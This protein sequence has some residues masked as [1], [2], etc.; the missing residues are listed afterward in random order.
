[1]KLEKACESRWA[2]MTRRTRASDATPCVEDCG[3]GT[4]CFCSDA[5]AAWPR[6]TRLCGLSLDDEASAWRPES[7][8]ALRSLLLRSSSHCIHIAEQG[9]LARRRCIHSL[10]FRL[11][12]SSCSHRMATRTDRTVEL[13]LPIC[14]SRC[15]WSG[16]FAVCYK[17]YKHRH[18]RVMLKA[19]KSLLVN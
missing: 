1:M 13:V 4:T 15:L 9:Q 14:R 5:G 3:C 12:N 10:L 6:A 17:H 7:V 11:S 18:S 8:L 16:L 19:S 2:S